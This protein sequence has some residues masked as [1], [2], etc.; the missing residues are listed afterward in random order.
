MGESRDH[1]QNCERLRSL[2][3]ATADHLPWPE[4]DRVL[5]ES[6]L[7]SCDSC[8]RERRLLTRVEAHL[9]TPPTM[10]NAHELQTRLRAAVRRR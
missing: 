6:H 4:K 3:A 8:Q 10:G 1:Q 2:L 7:A 5:A 9:S